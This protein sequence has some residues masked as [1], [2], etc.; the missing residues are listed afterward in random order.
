MDASR[1]SLLAGATLL[2]AAPVAAVAAPPSHPDA[3]LLALGAEL[4]A[5]WAAERIASKTVESDEELDRIC[6]HTGAIAHQI[7]GTPA[8]TLA[9]YRVKARAIS[10]CHDGEPVDLGDDS[11]A[12]DFANRLIADL[13]A[14]GTA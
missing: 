7:A 1:R 3:V 6:E 12:H 11:T 14:S 9:G 5:R 2:A 8:T 13:L 10:W 4:D